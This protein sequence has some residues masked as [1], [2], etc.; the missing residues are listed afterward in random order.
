[1]EIGTN[2]RETSNRDIEKRE[3]LLQHETQRIRCRYQMVGRARTK[4]KEEYQETDNVVMSYLP[5]S[6]EMD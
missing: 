5:T 1:M 2:E 6:D 4:E 3:T